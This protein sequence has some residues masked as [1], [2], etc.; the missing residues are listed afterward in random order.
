MTDQPKWLDM[1]RDRMLAEAPDDVLARSFWP[2]KPI[3]RSKV[4]LDGLFLI[5]AAVFALVTIAAVLI[6]PAAVASLIGV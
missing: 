3:R 5:A 1:E 6:D 4:S 2:G